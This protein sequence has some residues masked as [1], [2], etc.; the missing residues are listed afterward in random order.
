MLSE[1]DVIKVV[2]DYLTTKGYTITQQLKENERGDDIVACSSSGDEILILKPKVK[3][4]Q[5]Q[6]PLDLVNLL[7]VPRFEFMLLLHFLNQ[8]RS[9]EMI[10]NHRYALELPYPRHAITL[11]W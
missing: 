8:H 5:N 1:S 11:I 4:V 9:C 3:L 6:G 2:C 7:I 10:I